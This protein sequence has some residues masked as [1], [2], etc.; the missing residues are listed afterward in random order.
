MS[1]ASPFPSLSGKVAIV[2]GASRGIGAVTAQAFARAGASVV[3][4]ARDADALESVAASIRAEGGR[5]IA[6]PTDVG[7][8]R[9]QEQLVARALAEFGRLDFAFNNAT[10]GPMPAPLADY[11]V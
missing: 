7:D 5:A 9:A 6:V 1:T 3:L 11:D 4:A 10:D 2:A 8:Q